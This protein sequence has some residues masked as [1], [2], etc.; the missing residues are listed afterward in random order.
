MMKSPFRKVRGLGLQR[1]DKRHRVQRSSAQLDELSQA[2]QVFI[3]IV[4][5]IFMFV[6]VID[7]NRMISC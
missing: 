6:Y 3:F 4:V 2:S 1:N 7:L 5:L